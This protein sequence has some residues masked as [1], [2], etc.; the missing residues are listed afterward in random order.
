MDDLFFYIKP[1]FLKKSEDILDIFRKKID[2][3]NTFLLTDIDDFFIENIYGQYKWLWFY[4]KLFS[5]YRWK[6]VIVV[7]VSWNFWI[8]YLKDIIWN[9]DPVK[10]KT[11]TIRN[12]F[13]IDSLEKANFEK[14]IIDNVVHFQEDLDVMK[15]EL[16]FIKNTY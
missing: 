3:K 4:E 5:Y 10:A 8:D 14:R 16:Y 9:K 6:S 12:L 1:N 2:I 7:I 11:W 15:K 13:S